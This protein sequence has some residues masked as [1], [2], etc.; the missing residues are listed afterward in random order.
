M[1]REQLN[2]IIIAETN[3]LK[4]KI[5]QDITLN[6]TVCIFSNENTSDNPKQPDPEINYFRNYNQLSIIFF[7]INNKKSSG[8][9]GIPNISLKRLPNK[10]KWYYTVLLNNALNNTYFPRKWKKAKLIAITKK[11][12]G[13]TSPANLRPIA[14]FPT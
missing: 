5:E 4:N 2:R 9:D 10:I 7:M 8:F 6:K 1:C 3:K 12:K 11:D 14:S 13:G